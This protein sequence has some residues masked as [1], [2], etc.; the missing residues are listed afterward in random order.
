MRRTA[1]GGATWNQFSLDTTLNPA[2]DAVLADPVNSAAAWACGGGVGLQRSEDGNVTWQPLSSEFKTLAT[3]GAQVLYG[4]RT[5][6]PGAPAIEWSLDGGY[7]WT[8][9]GDPAMPQL[10]S[11]PMPLSVVAQ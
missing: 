9:I 4:V 7:T 1:D 2:E 3:M 5:W 11:L 8:N 10:W 6:T